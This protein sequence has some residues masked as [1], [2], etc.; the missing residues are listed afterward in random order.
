M[1]LLSVN[2]RSAKAYGGD[3][4]LAFDG[5]SD[6]V[7]FRDLGFMVG[8]SWQDTM[9]VS[10]WVKPTAAAPTVTDIFT[11]N[12]IVGDHP[13]WFGVYQANL[14]GQDRLW[15][16][17]HDNGE[18]SGQV[19]IGIDYTVG[20]WVHITW[21]HENDTLYAYKNGVFV[22]STASGSTA[23]GHP[24]ALNGIEL[25]VG[26]GVGSGWDTLFTGYIDEV[27]VW[28]VGRTQAQIQR[29]MYRSLTGSETGLSAYYQMSDGSGTTLTDN[30]GTVANNGVLEDGWLDVP[31]DGDTA[32]WIASGALAGPRQAL[33]FNGTNSYVDL[34][35]NANTIVGA[36]WGSTKSVSVWV[37]P[38]AVSP[39]TT[40]AADGTWIFGG[41][42]GVNGRWGI[43]QAE[44][45]GENK[46][47]VWNNDGLGEQRL[48]VDFTSSD[49]QQIS[50]VHDGGNLTAFLNGRQTGSLPSTGT[51]GD[52]TLY[53]GG[54]P[55]GQAFAG[56]L[57]ELRLWSSAQSDV[58]IQGNMFK[59][60]QGAESGLAAYYRFD[61][62][63]GTNLYNMAA[64]ANH[65]SLT[66]GPSWVSSNAFNTWIGSDSDDWHTAENWSLYTEPTAA[67]NVGIENYPN[68]NPPV[69]NGSAVADNLHINVGAS[70]EITSTGSLIANG[71]WINAG[72]LT[73]AGIMQQ[74]KV[75]DAG[76]TVSFFAD[77]NY[78]GVDIT[79]H[80]LDNLG[81]T[82]AVIQG[83]SDCTL[84]VSGTIQRCFDLSV[85]NQPTNGATIA[86]TFN[87]SEI[88]PSEICT[89]VNAY[90]YEGGGYWGDP[91]TQDSIDCSGDPNT[92]VVSGVTS[93]SP[94]A[95]KA[96]TA[97]TAV[98]LQTFGSAQNSYTQLFLVAIV[99]LVILSSYAV[100]QVKTR[101]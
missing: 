85:T 58:S 53:I 89:A 72:T 62:D 71:E 42:D 23:N 68:S 30:T 37:K 97:P 96:D 52:G 8:S 48:G 99:M 94:F 18:I 26:G 6:F 11:G 50:L 12:L 31:P 100:Y 39:V 13:R 86:F 43:S 44:I 88:P 17:N 47:W 90:H 19:A 55:G 95:L 80:A 93:M 78:G 60:I 84:P 27:R 16:T 77:G 83:N 32:A 81:S 20:E 21:V 46:I 64:D 67:D 76:Q 79:A 40:N 54:L 2:G 24:G 49:W 82:T 45:G 1:G 5:T 69:I 66:N 57:D 63:S 34:G 25:R 22:G 101:K 59:S 15:V 14:G 36:S 56:E 92:I 10:V 73:N 41:H 75:I 28:N 35:A 4:A 38:T 61:Q 9:T 7:T 74:T 98:T 87:D 70:L 3:Y 33:N 51:S 29:D 65:G 91:L